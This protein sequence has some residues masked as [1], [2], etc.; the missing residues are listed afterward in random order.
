MDS[1]SAQTVTT[2]QRAFLP[3]QNPSSIITNAN[4]LGV[5]DEWKAKKTLIFYKTD[6]KKDVD[7]FEVRKYMFFSLDSKFSKE[8]CK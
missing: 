7:K 3:G 4:S 8:I 2:F 6:V 5:K 1:P